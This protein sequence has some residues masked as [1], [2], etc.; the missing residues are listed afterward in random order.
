MNDLTGRKFSRWLVVSHSEYRRPH[1]LWL[2]RCECGVEKIIQAN[3]LLIGTTKSCGCLR[4]EVNQTLHRTHGSCGSPLYKAWAAM[5]ARCNNVNGAQYKN[6]GGRGITVCDRWNDFAKFQ[7]DMA[8]TWSVGMTVERIDVNK[9]YSPQNCKWIP[10]HEQSNNRRDTVYVET[11]EGRM[12]IRDAARR[13]G[14][15][16]GAMAGRI[17]NQWPIELMLLPATK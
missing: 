13:A 15:S 12:T 4:R 5:R 2:C 11:L 9:G 16:R 3:S 1:Q 14:V 17:A 8:P 7:L 6:Y 10:A